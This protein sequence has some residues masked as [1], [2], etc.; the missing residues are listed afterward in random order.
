MAECG[1]RE[2]QD[3]PRLRNLTR[4]GAPETH[5][6]EGGGPGWVALFFLICMNGAFKDYTGV[7]ILL[8]IVVPTIY[9]SVM[10]ARDH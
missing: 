6:L 9:V 3:D 2:R 7:E 8:A 10:L 4:H 5:Q 1:H